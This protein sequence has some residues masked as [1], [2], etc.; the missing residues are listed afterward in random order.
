MW[1]GGGPMRKR[2]VGSFSG[3]FAPMLDLFVK[4]KQALGYEYVG[5]YNALHVFD[6]FSKNYAIKNYEL[7]KDIVLD[8]AQKRPNENDTTRSMRIM[9]LQHFA[10]FL[11][12]QGY[13]GYLAPQQKYRYSQHTA[14]VFTEDEIRKFFSSLDEMTY[15]PCSPYRHLALPL[16]YR[17]LYG[18][19][20][21]ISELLNLTVGDV[22][23][24]NGI[25]HIR[26]AK[27]GNERFVP[28]AD[29]LFTRC[30]AYANEI[31]VNHDP[32]FPFFFKKDGSGYCVSNIEKHF[33][34][35]LWLAGI[36]YL[37]K[38]LGPRVHD[39]RHTFICHRL[40]QWAKDDVDLTAMLPILS[41]YVGH[42][43][44]ASTQYYLKLTAEAFPDVLDRMDELTGYVFPEVGGDLYED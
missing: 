21:R 5:G 13:Y 14:Y 12:S 23:S 8:W 26:D 33:R 29:S 44:I 22:D 1:I 32:N 27:N 2:T 9:Y 28:M 30:R 11:N 10:S 19:G 42:T 37:G 6:T 34:E 3:P 36:P 25:V 31:H 16:L 18:C 15:S 41:K 38:E 39:L 4:Q 35:Q 17:M 20:F 7:T 43:G 40:N 24:E